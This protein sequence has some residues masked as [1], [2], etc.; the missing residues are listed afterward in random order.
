MAAERRN[1]EKHAKPM[2]QREDQH[3]MDHDASL[4]ECLNL[5]RSAGDP[6]RGVL[7]QEL[8]EISQ[9]FIRAIGRSSARSH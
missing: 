1:V 2:Q 6:V 9:V 8:V 4:H 7:L 3:V 5:A